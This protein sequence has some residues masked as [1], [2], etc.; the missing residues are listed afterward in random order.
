MS[1]SKD[2]MRFELVATKSSGESIQIPCE[3]FREFQEEAKELY[4]DYSILAVY[5]FNDK[6]FVKRVNYLRGKKSWIILK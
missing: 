1:G 4:S 6:G 3:S 2:K 5:G